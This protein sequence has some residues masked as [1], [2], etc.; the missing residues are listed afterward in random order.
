MRIPQIRQLEQ[1][2]EDVT[3]GGPEVQ[4]EPVVL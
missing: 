1:N 4:K 2:A 3:V